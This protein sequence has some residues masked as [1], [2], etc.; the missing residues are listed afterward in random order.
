[1]LIHANKVVFRN[2]FRALAVAL[3]IVGAQTALAQV[4]TTPTLQ[5]PTPSRVPPPGAAPVGPVKTGVFLY[6]VQELDFSRHT[7]HANFEVWFRWRGDAFDPL[8]NFHVVDARSI[9]VIGRGSAQAWP[10]AKIMLSR[11]STR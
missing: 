9:T 11:A 4:Q 7:F 3:F 5:E 1:M 6:S 10:M 8:A 2:V